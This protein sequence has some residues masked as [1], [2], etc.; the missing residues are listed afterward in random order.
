MALSSLVKQ[1]ADCKSPRD[2]LIGL[3]MDFNSSISRGPTLGEISYALAEITEIKFEIAKSS[4]NHKLVLKS[5][6]SPQYTRFP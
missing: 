4:R 2:W 1:T 5:E 3:A 6:I